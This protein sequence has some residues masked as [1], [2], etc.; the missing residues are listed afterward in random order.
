MLSVYPVKLSPFLRTQGTQD[1]VVEHH[2]PLAELVFRF[3][4]NRVHFPELCGEFV[5]HNICGKATRNS[6]FRC[7]SSPRQVTQP[8]HH[9]RPGTITERC[10]ARQWFSGFQATLETLCGSR[11]CEVKMLE[12][13]GRAPL[14]F[15]V[16]R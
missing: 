9:K 8:N 12:N 11:V 3:G 16:T 2:R 14:S 5:Q 1:R 10:S 4:N 7:V 13:F 15:R 6:R